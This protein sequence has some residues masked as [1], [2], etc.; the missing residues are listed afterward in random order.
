ME[1]QAIAKRLADAIA[2]CREASRADLL[3]QFS[4][5]VEGCFDEAE[6]AQAFATVHKVFHDWMDS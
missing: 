2:D 3:E 5:I 6:F 4:T 1:T